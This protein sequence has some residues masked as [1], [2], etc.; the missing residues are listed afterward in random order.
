MSNL[1][2]AIQAIKAE[3]AHA[4][5]GAAFYQSRITALEEAL[6]RIDSVETGVAQNKDSGKTKRAGKAIG[7]AKRGRKP[8]A[9]VEEGSAKLPSTG[10]D[11][12]PNLITSE[13][14]SAPEILNAAVKTLGIS[15]TKEQMKKLSQRQTSALNNMVKT[16]L[17]QDS[18][19]GRE[20]R[21]FRAQ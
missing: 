2:S 4:K 12:W 11:F 16:Q 15:P 20:R 13:P 9:Q 14:R 1:K 18:G 5:E 7:G 10:K 21:F 17:I 19:S 8:R 6:A 3:L